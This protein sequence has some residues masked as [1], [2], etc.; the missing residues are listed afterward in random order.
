MAPPPPPA[1]RAADAWVVNETLTP[2]MKIDYSHVDVDAVVAW[3]TAEAK[4]R[5]PDAELQWAS[6]DGV[7]PDGHAD[8]TLK[9]FASDHGMIDV[10]FYSP[11]HAGVRDPKVPR[12]VKTDTKCMFRIWVMPRDGAE[13][14]DMSSFADCGKTQTVPAPRCSFAKVWSNVLAKRGDLKDAVA[15]IIYTR[16][17]VS[18]R[19]VWM[20]DIH[21]VFSEQLP[22]GC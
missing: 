21:E 11:S 8:L 14:H 2:P 9:S 1:K 18:H 10:R 6:A 7:Y 12:G 17:I 16:N 20:F 15:Q 13:L 4:K 22:D 19:V 3:A 5:V